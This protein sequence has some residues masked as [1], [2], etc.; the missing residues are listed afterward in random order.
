MCHYIKNNLLVQ[1]PMLWNK[2]LDNR[3]EQLVPTVIVVL[4]DGAGLLQTP[5]SKDLPKG[6]NYTPNDLFRCPAEPLD[7]LS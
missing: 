2:Q 6:W 1:L 4:Y 7:S 5:G 3:G